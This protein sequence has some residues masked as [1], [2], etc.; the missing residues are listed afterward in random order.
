[1]K[2]RLI[3]Q[4]VKK[5]FFIVGILFSFTA[6]AQKSVCVQGKVNLPEGEGYYVVVVSPEYTVLTSGYYEV[7]EFRTKEVQ[8]DTFIVQI[9]SPS[10][11]GTENFSLNNRRKEKVIDIGKVE[12]GGSVELQSASVI[13]RR[14]HFRVTEGKMI[15][16]ISDNNEYQS[17]P[18]VLEVM[19]NLPLVTVNND[20]VGVFGKKNTVILVNGQPAK[21]DSWEFIQ[22]ENIR[23]IEVLTNPPARYSAAGAAVINIVTRRNPSEGL[24][25]QL[26]ASVSKGKYGRT[27]SRLQLGYATSKLNL[28]TNIGYSPNK[29]L[30]VENYD[31]YFGDGTELQN[32]LRQKRTTSPAYNLLT[33]GDYRIGF[34]HT[35][36]MQY[37]R[38]QQNW[39]RFTVNSTGLT[40]SDSRRTLFLTLTSAENEVVRNI[41]DLNYVFAIDS[42]GKRL[43]VGVGYVDYH[44]VE[45]SDMSET[46]NADYRKSKKSDSEA[47]V[48]LL[49]SNIDYEH[50]T[51][52]GYRF[53]IGAYGARSEDDSYYTL[54]NTTAEKPVP[55][56]DFSNGLLVR[57]N[58]YAAYTTAGKS[59][60]SFSLSAGLRYEHVDYKSTGRSKTYDDLFPSVEIGYVFGEKLR[61]DL[62]YSRKTNRPAFQDLDPSTIYVDTL[63]YFRGNTGL[64]PEYSH[65]L[66]LNVIYNRYFVLSLG[67]SRIDDPLYM[68]V[69]KLRPDT[70]ICVATTEN[71]KSED[72]WTFSLSAPYQHGRWTTHNSLGVTYNRTR[73]DIEKVGY[74]PARTLFYA[75]SSHNFRFPAGIALFFTYQYHSSGQSGIFTFNK[76]HVLRCGSSVSLLSDRLTLT[77][78]YDDV[79]HQD[80]IHNRANLN[81]LHFIYR[82]KYDSSC[83]TFSL[84]Y[85]FGK[86]TRNY[87]IKSNAA[88]EM[89]RI[90]S[91]R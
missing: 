57:E 65:N 33:G 84:R 41:Y 7:P 12:L 48:S 59:W 30:F 80:R 47:E 71:L 24:N 70:R 74:E 86:S 72:S 34:R 78:R 32:E 1:M 15:H 58:K 55:D 6:Y 11:V 45:N 63:T 66:V 89:K 22:P 2:S 14:P 50:V 9:Y 82:S 17:L 88:E 18:S 27:D 54:Y 76:Q 44:S 28:Y 60:G 23:S 91:S 53:T 26:F 90:K 35:I 62:S 42:L 83:L 49:T 36:D 13:G 85:K 38:I 56:A 61:A 21:N 68:S 73:F 8:A 29:R 64:R 37:Q 19:K 20:K 67:Y 39:E 79:L 52:L 87:H 81:D 77:L 51:M 69:H 3:F 25:G 5:S 43:T 40:E 75:F 10:V 16:D 4:F 46:T 31:R